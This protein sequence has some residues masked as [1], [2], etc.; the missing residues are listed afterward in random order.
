MTSTKGAPSCE[1]CRHVRTYGTYFPPI[2]NMV[3]SDNIAERLAVRQRQ[4]GLIISMLTGTC[5]QSGRFFEPAAAT[6]EQVTL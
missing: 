4:G 6:D 1:Q 3:P 2:C 5:G